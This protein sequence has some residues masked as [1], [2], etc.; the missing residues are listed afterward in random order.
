MRLSEVVEPDD[1]T[2]AVR[3]MTAATMQAA[4]RVALPLPWSF[5]PPQE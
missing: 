5:S 2:E 3:L 4:R 1:V